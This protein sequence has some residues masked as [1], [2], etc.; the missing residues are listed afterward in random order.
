MLYVDHVE[1]HGRALYA[2][3][4][5][6]D[7]EG[8]VAKPLISPYRNIGGK[9]PWIKIRNPKYSQKEGRAEQFNKR[10]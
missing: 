2:E 1:E 9:S 6:R 5:K 7:L 3:T 8:I 10:R 4:L